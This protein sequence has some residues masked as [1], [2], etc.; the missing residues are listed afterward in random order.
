MVATYLHL[1]LIYVY[2][3]DRMPF[4]HWCHFFGASVCLSVWVRYEIEGQRWRLPLCV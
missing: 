4:H 3:T 2:R 1:L